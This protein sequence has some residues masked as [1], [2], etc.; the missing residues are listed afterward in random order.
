MTDADLKKMRYVPDAL[1]LA[2]IVL[3]L[4]ILARPND[5]VWTFSAIL[6]CGITDALDGYIARKYRCESELGA[7][8]DSLGDFVFFGAVLAYFALWHRDLFRDNGPMLCAIASV[9]ILSLAVCGIRNRRIYSL[10]T[11]GNKVT[12]LVLFAGIEAFILSG[13]GG[14]VFFLLFLAL[15]SALEELLIFLLKKAPDA[16]VKS[17][18]S[19]AGKRR[20]SEQADKAEQG[21]EK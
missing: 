13:S 14:V 5:R 4:L 9:R 7:R 19:L 17:V 16:N 20:D 8:L 2:R 21:K 1:S 3:S 11:V 10:H 6:L 12:G 15:A 18:F